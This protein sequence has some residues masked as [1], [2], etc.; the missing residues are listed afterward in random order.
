MDNSATI[1]LLI[2]PLAKKKKT[3]KIVEEIVTVLSG[4]KCFAQIGDEVSSAIF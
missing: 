2:N 3:N 1:L 4:R